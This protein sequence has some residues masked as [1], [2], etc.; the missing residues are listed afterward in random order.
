MRHKQHEFTGGRYCL[1]EDV[2]KYIV[3]NVVYTD[4]RMAF[5]K[6]WLIKMY[7][8]VQK[9]QLI[10]LHMTE[11]LVKLLIKKLLRKTLN[12]LVIWVGRWLTR[13]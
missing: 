4:F 9:V 11:K 13:I 10:N 3:V 2:A 12:Q 1:F 8:V 7:K 5:H 6:G